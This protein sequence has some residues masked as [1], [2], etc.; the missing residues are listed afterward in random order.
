MAMEPEA[1]ISPPEGNGEPLEN[2]SGGREG[3]WSRLG[4]KLPGPGSGR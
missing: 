3:P 4:R 1:R 2:M